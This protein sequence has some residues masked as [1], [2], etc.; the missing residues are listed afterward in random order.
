MDLGHC[1]HQIG[2][3]KI[4]RD[5]QRFAPGD[6]HII[7]RGLNGKRREMPKRFAQA[8]PDPVALDGAASLLRH[9]QAD[10][11]SARRQ[12][13]RRAL[14]GK[15]PHMHAF[16]LGSLQEIRAPAQPLQACRRGVP[17]R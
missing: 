1:A 11:G 10:T 4:E 2:L 14:E 6:D 17:I 9:G 7:M 15:G 8:P 12:G 13:P 3:Q 5:V 16:A